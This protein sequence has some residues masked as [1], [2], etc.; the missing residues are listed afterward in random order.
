MIAK[1]CWGTILD[2]KGGLS[3]ACA[4]SVIFYRIPLDPSTTSQFSI[5]LVMAMLHSQGG[6][7]PFPDENK[8]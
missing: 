4:V 2:S 3:A 8:V 6:K 1:S 7:E 5:V